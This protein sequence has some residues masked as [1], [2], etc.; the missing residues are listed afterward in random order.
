M[1]EE[2]KRA[3]ALEKEITDKVSETNDKKIKT[4]AKKIADEKVKRTTEK[5]TAELDEAVSRAET[6]R[7]EKEAAEQRIAELERKLR[8]SD[9]VIVTAKAY[10]SAVQDNFSKLAALITSAVTVLDKCRE[11]IG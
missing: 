3:A 7:A 1:T 4:E 8:N 5:I 2:E 10:L 9:T 6:I 11:V